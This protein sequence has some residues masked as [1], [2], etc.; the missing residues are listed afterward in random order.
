MGFESL[1][2]HL[3]AWRLGASYLTY[4]SHS[5]HVFNGNDSSYLE[6]WLLRI[7]EIKH[8]VYPIE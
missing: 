2:C 1:L 3:Q 5:L 7:E 6:R 4:E 8:N